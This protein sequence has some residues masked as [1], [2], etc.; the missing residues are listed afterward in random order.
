M[1]IIHK[2]TNEIIDVDI[3]GGRYKKNYLIIPT[4]LV[5]SDYILTVENDT[6]VRD[7]VKE[8]ARERE[9][10]KQSI[11]KQLDTNQKLYFRSLLMPSALVDIND[12][13]SE[14]YTEMYQRIDGELRQQLEEVS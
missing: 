11:Y 9:T 14:T 1:N 2:T 13:N 7:T 4:E 12:P 3:F 5:K 6:V 8:L 10:T